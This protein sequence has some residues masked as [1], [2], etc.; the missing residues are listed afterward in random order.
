MDKAIEFLQNPGVQSQDATRKIS[1][2][3]A[4]GMSDDDI[5]EAAIHVGDD[6]VVEKLPKKNKIVIP[7]KKFTLTELQQYRGEDGQPLYLSCKGIVYEVDPSFYGPKM[8]YHAFSGVDCSR[9]L[10][11]VV[12]GTNESNQT[13]SDLSEKQLKTLKEWED[14]YQE[15]YSIKGTIEFSELSEPNSSTSSTEKDDNKKSEPKGKPG[16]AHQ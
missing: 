13:W 5:R 1:F 15:K 16:C 14:K 12:V 4:K 10:A 11:K 2:L 8:A 6:D 3:K 9:H 7:E